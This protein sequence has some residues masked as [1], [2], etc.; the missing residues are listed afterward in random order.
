MKTPQQFST[1]SSFVGGQWMTLALVLIA[2]A[3][4]TSPNTLDISEKI[5]TPASIDRYKKVDPTDWRTCFLGSATF[6]EMITSEYNYLMGGGAPGGFEIWDERGES[7]MLSESSPVQ[8]RGYVVLEGLFHEFTDHRD[9]ALKKFYPKIRFDVLLPNGQPPALHE[10][11]GVP[12]EAPA[13]MSDT[14]STFAE[15]ERVRVYGKAFS[16][17][18]NQTHQWLWLSVT[19]MEKVEPITRPQ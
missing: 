4:C 14:V 5:P 2:S 15:S 3:G 17:N 12:C 8:F 19:K 11:P 6:Q 1:L 9:P 10:E 18:V 13:A 7:L 16:V